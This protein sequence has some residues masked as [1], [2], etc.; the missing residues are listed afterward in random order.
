[1]NDP[2]KLEGAQVISFPRMLKSG[3]R[4]LTIELTEF[5]SRKYEGMLSILEGNKVLLNGE[6]TA[7]EKQDEHQLPTG[8]VDKVTGEI[9]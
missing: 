4:R 5:D 6:F 7:T 3:L 9:I 2:I 1:M 8:N